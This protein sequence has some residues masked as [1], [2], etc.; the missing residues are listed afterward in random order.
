MS[1]RVNIQYSVSLEELEPELAR[2]LDDALS[3]LA[4]L[5]ENNARVPTGLLS[6]SVREQLD[7]VRQSLASIDARI[8]EVNAMIEAFLSYKTQQIIQQPAATPQSLQGMPDL[9]S[10]QN[11]MPDFDMSSPDLAGL[12][13]KIEA[14][15]NSTYSGGEVSEESD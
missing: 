15:R 4:S 8:G 3:Q 13:E 7:S 5:S 1:E 11:S 14:F 10:L 12:R 9:S 2:L 6:L